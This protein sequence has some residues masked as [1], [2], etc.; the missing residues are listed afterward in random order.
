MVFDI[1]SCQK[2]EK[3]YNPTLNY[4]MSELFQKLVELTGQARRVLVIAHR[5][6]DPDTLGACVAMKMWMD[7][8]GKEVTLACVDKPEAR[9][10]FLPNI[11]K[12]VQEFDLKNFDLKMILDSGASYMTN[13]QLKYE[14][15]FET[16]IPIINIDHHASNDLYG[17]LNIVDQE[18]ASTTVLIYRFFRFVNQK[19]DEKLATALLAG[20]YS[21]TGGFMHSNTNQ[22]VYEISSDLMSHGAKIAK[23]NSFLFQNKDAATLRLWGRVLENARMMSDKSVVSVIRDHDF[24]AVD[25]E[26]SQLSGVVDYLTMVPGARFA[27][28]L[29]EDRRGNVKGS[30]RTREKNVDVA[31]MAAKFGG[32]GHPKASGFMVHG[33]LEEGSSYR[34]VSADLSKKSLD[35]E[36]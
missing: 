9:F 10:S 20:L 12:F 6:P 13:F 11:D 28:L 2:R 22:E 33:N 36:F 14:H 17:T 34:I 15:L 35:L 23:I 30:F 8:L 1:R 3:G 5:H 19:I 25:A 4:V 7:A 18:A 31:E 24:D 29:N 32:G 16:G 26:P 27:L 21:D